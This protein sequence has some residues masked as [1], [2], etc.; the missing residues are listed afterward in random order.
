MMNYSKIIF[1]LIFIIGMST[2]K[3]IYSQEIDANAALKESAINQINDKKYSEAIDLL[4][5]YISSV[6][7]DTDGY[8]L[9]G[10]CFE[11]I[12]QYQNAVLDLRRAVKL[13]GNNTTARVVLARTE[14]LWHKQLRKKILGHQREIAISPYTAV[15]YLEIGKSYR[16]L[17]EWQNA[18][19]WYDSYLERDEDASADEIIRYSE[20]LAKNNHIS[21]GEKILKK[22][23]DRY[24]NDW[25]LWSRYGYF[26]L[27]LAKYSQSQKAFEKALG[28]KPFFKEAQDGLDMV[29]RKA[30]VT[31]NNPRAFEKEYPIDRFYRLLRENPKDDA[32]R[33]KLADELIK[34]NRIEEA[35]QQIEILGSSNFDDPKFNEK[36]DYIVSLRDSSYQQ[37]IE[38]LQTKVDNNPTDKNSVQKLAEYF[39]LLEEYDEAIDLLEGYFELVPDESDPELKFEYAHALAWSRYFEDSGVVLDELIDEYP[40]NL[41]YILFRAQISIWTETD[42][43]LADEYVEE[44]LTAKPNNFDALIAK[45]ALL[46]MS[47][48]FEAAQETI[49]KARTIG[50][51]N[52]EIVTIQSRLD[53]Q[54]IRYKERQIYEILEKGQQVLADEGCEEAIPY[55]EEYLQKAEPNNLVKREYGNVLSCAEH[56]EEALLV[57][58]EILNDGY[59]YKTEL[60]RGKL[61]YQI[62]D[63]LKSLETF[64]FL[65]EKEPNEFQPRLFLG[66][67]YS[68]LNINDSA[69]AVYDTLLTW[70]LDSLQTFLVEKRISWIPPTG[71]KAIIAAFPSSIFISP[72]TQFYF[73]NLSFGLAKVGGRIEL[74]LFQYFAI[75]ISFDRVNTSSNWQS[76]DSASVDYIQSNSKSGFTGV[77][78]FTSFKGFARM[79]FTQD[80]IL[81]IALGIVNTATYDGQ[82]ETEVILDYDNK[83]NFGASIVYVKSDANLILY[84]P[85]LIDYQTP[86]ESRLSASLMRIRGNYKHSSNFLVSSVFDYIDISDGNAGNNF[87]LHLG[88]QFTK[89]FSA[90]YEY[91]YQNFRYKNEYIGGIYYSPQNFDSHSLWVDFYLENLEHNKVLIGGKIGYVAQS[92]QLVLEG[93][94]TAK[95]RL[96]KTLNIQGDLALGQSSQFYSTYRY[97]SFSLSVNWG[98]W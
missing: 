20:I 82:D 54:I 41:D 1:V 13:D 94:L 56:Y 15:N 40:N 73:D 23:V 89:P 39:R 96:I 57:Y 97:F 21:K 42:L 27:W 22:Y 28:F 62:G 19:D 59:D 26:T 30:Y 61:Y 95:Y 74:G 90:G 47:S 29:T 76:L 44:V 85:Y 70:E 92:S 52:N 31:Q 63:S 4:N 51:E 55:Y 24:P 71:L 72:Q 98:F 9:R 48:D 49:D 7:R 58:N 17:E 43:D 25:R 5:K 77:R 35:Y 14:D 18:E 34:A 67:T 60:E 68:K 12:G 65:V 38:E 83:N 69:L 32:S 75:G 16:W 46:I 50:G 10:T 45:S 81:S 66:D 3:E 91:Y 93:H 6:P 86:D 36:W 2:H 64:K 79:S 53:F 84:S 37:K 87:L 80:L 11:N 88:Y 33:F 78:T 8:T